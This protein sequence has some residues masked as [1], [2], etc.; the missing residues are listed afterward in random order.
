MQWYI[1]NDNAWAYFKIVFFD[2]S[3]YFNATQLKN[4]NYKAIELKNYYN[5]IDLFN[6]IVHNNKHL[7]NVVGFIDLGKNNDAYMNTLAYVTDED[8]E[9]MQEMPIFIGVL[10]KFSR[11]TETPQHPRPVRG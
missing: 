8:V 7:N 10:T 3:F 9:R 11:R 5:L 4:A 2:N 6:G 1:V